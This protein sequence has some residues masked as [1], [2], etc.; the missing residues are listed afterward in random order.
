M[1]CTEWELNI[2]FI[3]L[4]IPILAFI[5]QE[6]LNKEECCF[7]YCLKT[8]KLFIFF[9]LILNNKWAHNKVR[10]DELHI[11]LNCIAS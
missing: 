9:I 8:E 10:I 1:L 3:S 2:L 7:N 4:K 5:L 6:T 11:F